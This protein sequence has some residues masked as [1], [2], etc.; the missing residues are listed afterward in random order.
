MRAHH[1]ELV[2]SPQGTGSATPRSTRPSGPPRTGFGAVTGLA[3]AGA[4]TAGA[5]AI[6]RHRR[7]H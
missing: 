1:E 6:A 4:L 3:G 2:I 7:R 5:V